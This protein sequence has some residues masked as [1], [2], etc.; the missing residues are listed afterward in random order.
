MLV[1]VGLGPGDPE[2]LTLRAIRLLG[3][4]DAVFV[5]GTLARSLVAPYRPDAEVLEFPMTGDEDA[6]DRCL[7]ENAARIAPVARGG[8]A[9]FGIIGDPNF[10]ST[11]SRLCRVID[12]DHPGIEWR[13][14]P[15]VSAITAGASVADFP[16]SGGVLVSDGS[17][18]TTAIRMKVRRPRE[19]AARLADEG[20]R[21]CVLVERMGMTGERVYREPVLPEESDYFSIM[22]ARKDDGDDTYRGRRAG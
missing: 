7:R 19:T 21:G 1:A 14:V 16:V 4:A 13:T 5:P 10:Y 22:Y 9:V 20:Y 12:R 11:F 6:I 2:L 18:V 17:P 3:E 15:G 8:C